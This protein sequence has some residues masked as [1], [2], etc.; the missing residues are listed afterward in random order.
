MIIV[1]ALFAVVVVSAIVV[2]VL[3]CA[4]VTFNCHA[5]AEQAITELHGRI[6]MHVSL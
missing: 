6:S 2:V 3:G 4:F 1:V 5:A